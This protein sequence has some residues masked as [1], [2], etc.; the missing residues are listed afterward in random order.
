MRRPV[1]HAMS[2]RQRHRCDL[3]LRGARHRGSTLR[4]F[5]R[6]EIEGGGHQRACIGVLGRGH[7]ALGRAGFDD[8]SILHDQDV[9]GERANDPQIVADEQI[10]EAAALPAIRAR[11]RRSAPAPT[12]RAPRSARRGRRGAAAA[13]GHGR[14]RC[15]GAGRRR[16]RAGSGRPQRDQARPR[17]VRSRSAAGAR[18]RS[19][20]DGGRAAPPRRSAPPTAAATGSN[21]GPERRSASRAATAAAAALAQH[22]E[23]RGR[24]TKSVPAPR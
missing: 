12:C 15:A 11:A 10:S 19:P 1:G 22:G 2:E 16:I 18:R 13:P 8:P 4:V 24:Q 7:D 3:G 23:C 20:Q 14:S 6:G 5:S 17:R 21:T 9:V